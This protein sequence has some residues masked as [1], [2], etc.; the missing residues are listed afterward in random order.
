LH[1]LSHT[2]RPADTDLHGSM[3]AP[4]FH[5]PAQLTITTSLAPSPMQQHHQPTQVNCRPQRIQ[6]QA[7]PPVPVLLCYPAR[8]SSSWLAHALCSTS[9]YIQ[10]PDQ[11]DSENIPCDRNNANSSSTQCH[12][13]ATAHRALLNL[14]PTPAPSR[15][16]RWPLMPGPSGAAA[17]LS[18]SCA[19]MRYRLVLRP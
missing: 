5:T 10:L 18:D 4:A 16:Q 12:R 8:T 9:P 14:A 1:T 6:Q 7:R 13:R 3:R 17:E 15:R 2:W 19:F 11:P